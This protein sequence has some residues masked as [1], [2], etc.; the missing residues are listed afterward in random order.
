VRELSRYAEVLAAL[1]EPKLWPSGDDPVAPDEAAHAR[2]RAS[3]REAM[4]PEWTTRI[5]APVLPPCHPLDLIEDFARPWCRKLAAAVTGAAT[6]DLPRLLQLAEETSVATAMEQDAS[7]P[8]DQLKAAFAA[9]DVPMASSAFVALSHTLGYLLGNMWLALLR[10]PAELDRLRWEP[11]LMPLAVEEMMRRGGLTRGLMREATAD[12][13]IAGLRIARGE[14]IVLRIDEANRDPAQFPDPERLDV[15]RRASG[16]LT[17]GTAGHACV[18]GPL[19]RAAA[20]VL[21]SVWVAGLPGARLCGEVEW[22]GGEGFRWAER[23]EVE[24][25]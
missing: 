1:R 7:R 22:R 20:V 19:L 11:S 23:V 17:L 21:T 9:S 18:G 10:H 5:D 13:E 3:A 14:R 24:Y 8:N 12:V 16:Q 2:L 6:A 25:D 4:T 15:G